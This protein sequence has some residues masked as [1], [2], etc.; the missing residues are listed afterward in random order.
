M[1]KKKNLLCCR[2]LLTIIVWCTV[3]SWSSLDDDLCVGSSS[4][5]WHCVDIGMLISIST[6]L[7]WRREGSRFFKSEMRMS[8]SSSVYLQGWALPC[9]IG[10]IS[11]HNYL[12][13]FLSL[14]RP[15][16]EMGRE[17]GQMAETTGRIPLWIIGTVTSILVIGL[18][19][20]FFYGS[21]S[22]SSA[23]R[24]WKRRTQAWYLFNAGSLASLL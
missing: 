7:T 12:W 23:L 21:Y 10:R 13:L 1:N 22:G 19:G 18:V 11:S 9:V 20:I 2:R 6:I 8:F 15:L 17:V 16:D 3:Y 5:C 14:A 24:L 4:C